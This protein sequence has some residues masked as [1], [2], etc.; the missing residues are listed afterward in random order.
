MDAI[1]DAEC[2][3]ESS[4]I[5]VIVEDT[6]FR[7]DSHFLQRESETL[8]GMINSSKA[9]S[10]HLDGATLAEFRALWRY[11]YEGMYDDYKPSTTEWMDLLSIANTYGFTKVYRRAVSEIDD[12]EAAIDPVERIL[13]AK[14][15]KVNRWLSPAYAAL[16]LR[17]DPIT[18][19]EAE[20]LGMY[21]FVALV[22][23]RESFYRETSAPN[24][25]TKNLVSLVTPNLR[26]CGHA[27]AMLT[28]STSGGR[29]CPSCCQEVIRAPT[30]QAATNNNNRRCCNYQPYQ[31][32]AQPDGSQ[33]C[34]NCKGTVVPALIKIQ[35]EALATVNRVFGLEDDVGEAAETFPDGKD[36][37]PKEDATAGGAKK[38]KKGR[39]W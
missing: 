14:R 18:A 33:R 20:K 12:L 27:P 36:E 39:K 6:K 25:S 3:L 37:P 13:L 9:D 19:S 26:C 17:T 24:T 7:L 10:I 29:N 21:T 5:T 8:K 30:S 4:M 34:P 32:Q 28:V 2:F 22:A 1:P 23:A 11:F 16:C 35:E 38:M 31:W 15:L